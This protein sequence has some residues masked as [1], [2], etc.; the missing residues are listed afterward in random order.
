MSRYD[1]KVVCCVCSVLCMSPFIFVILL[2]CA[3]KVPSSY[4]DESISLHDNI[5]IPSDMNSSHQENP[6]L[7]RSNQA[8]DM[9]K[10]DHGN[11]LSSNPTMNHEFP[12]SK[13]SASWSD[14]LWKQLQY[15]MKKDPSHLSNV[16]DFDTFR[17]P[18]YYNYED[19]F[20]ALND[21]ILDEYGLW[22]DLYS[23]N[24]PNNFDHNGNSNEN[25][26]DDFSS[27]HPLFSILS[28][29]TGTANSS[30]SL[31]DIIISHHLNSIISTQNKSNYME[32]VRQSPEFRLPPWD[33]LT[34]NLQNDFLKQA[35]GKPQK[36]S[37]KTVMGLT[38]YYSALLSVG[39]PGNGLTILIILTNSYMRTAPNIFLLNIALADL[40][41]LTLGKIIKKIYTIILFL[42]NPDYNF[43]F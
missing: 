34:T 30:I 15:N 29:I 42:L 39:I 18:F 3:A 38:T 32:E 22:D 11:N 16:S 43:F 7:G 26:T 13:E 17:I 2:I 20:P 41:T 36:Y 8:H 4:A 5:K 6:I 27:L 10:N 35:L 37:N 28:N 33:N 24:G 23:I 31:S 40:L 1:L 9:N 19:Y 21:S 12:T 14:E 25:S